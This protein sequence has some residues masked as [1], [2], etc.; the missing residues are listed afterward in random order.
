MRVSE[1]KASRSKSP[2]V[3]A[4]GK[5]DKSARNE[6]TLDN[7][8]QLSKSPNTRKRE[9]HIEELVKF[10]LYH[11][12]KMAHLGLRPKKL[13]RSNTFNSRFYHTPY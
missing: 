13:A 1:L 8:K 12:L 9:E 5:R 6:Y 10:P 2:F 7:S 3:Q 4:T 11:K